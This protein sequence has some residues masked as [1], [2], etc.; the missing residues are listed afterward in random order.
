[1]A[2]PHLACPAQ[3]LTCKRTMKSAAPAAC[4]ACFAALL[5]LDTRVAQAD[6]GVETSSESAPKEEFDPKSPRAALRA[7]L[8]LAREEQHDEATGYLQAPKAQ[9]E[10]KAELAARL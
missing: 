1:M 4:I 8:E 5:F 9:A 7:F 6:A 2:A 10:R 3:W